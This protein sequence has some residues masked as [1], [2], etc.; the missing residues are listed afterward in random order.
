MPQLKAITLWKDTPITFEQFCRSHPFMVQ[1]I[2]NDAVLYRFS[3]YLCAARTI[4]LH[5]DKRNLF[6]T[7]GKGMYSDYGQCQMDVSNYRPRL[8]T[9]ISQ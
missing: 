9:Y 3:N 8:H 6:V 7:D 4:V 1:R 2:D 5:E